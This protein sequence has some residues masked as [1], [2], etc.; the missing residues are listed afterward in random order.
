MASG[1]KRRLDQD[2]KK[3]CKI[4]KGKVSDFIIT[5]DIFYFSILRY[6]FGFLVPPL[7]QQI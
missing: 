1:V 5:W 7:S 6:F 3:C 4:E 2:T